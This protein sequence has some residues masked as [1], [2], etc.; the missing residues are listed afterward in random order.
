MR[1]P[2]N[3]GGCDTADLLEKQATG[4]RSGHFQVIS[5]RHALQNKINIISAACHADGANR[6]KGVIATAHEGLATL[7]YKFPK[8]SHLDT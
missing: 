6:S 3:S 2:S 7:L 5:W 4:M 1:A 8:L